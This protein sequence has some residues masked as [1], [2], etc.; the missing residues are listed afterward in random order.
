[1]PDGLRS[2]LSNPTVQQLFVWSIASAVV[3]A[4]LEPFLGEVRAT[5]NR[6]AP[7]ARIS[8]TDAAAAVARGFWAASR[9]EAEAADQGLSAERFGLLVEAAKQDLDVGSLVVAMRR[10]LI[11]RGDL[12][13]ALRRRG[14]RDEQIR[15][16]PELAKQD[17]SPEAI[18]NAYL[19]GQIEEAEARRLFEK[20]GGNPEYFTLLFNA[21]GTAPT[22]TQALEL[23]NRGIIPWEGRG[24]DVVSYEQAFLE[25]PWRNKWL[26]PFRA[27]GEYLP[28]PRTITAMYR[29]GSIT[30]ERA[31]DLLRKQGLAPDLAEAYLRSGTAQKTERQ[32][33]LAVGTIRDLYRD[34]LVDR[35][36]AASMLGSLGYD[37][38]EADWLLALEEVEVVRRFLNAALTRLRSLYLA[39]KI[40]RSTVVAALGR[41]EVPADQQSDILRLWD[42]EAGVT[43][44]QLSPAQIV[45]AFKLGLLGQAEAQAALEAHGYTPWDA[46]A[47]LS[48]GMKQRLPGEPA[49]SALPGP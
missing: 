32:R 28:P 12:E 42:L 16:V 46:W 35:P 11:A 44:A 18:L 10:G 34:R 5:V 23:A 21:Q 17:P 25:G 39:R 19:Q 27:L 2:L 40:D 37:A 31:L 1:M 45:A 8:P 20:V 7:N 6:A 9:G 14:L 38:D 48:I 49:K 47:L 26:R 41:L 24:A 30:R 3:Q 22:P 15:L 29:E 43:V 13:A 4:A 36:T 33:D